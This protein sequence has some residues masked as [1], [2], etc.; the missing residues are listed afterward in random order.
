MIDEF[1]NEFKDYILWLGL[2]L[3]NHFLFQNPNKGGQLFVALMSSK[4]RKSHSAH[5]PPP[6]KKKS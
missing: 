4:I 3:R 2:E 6:Q 1:S 5:T